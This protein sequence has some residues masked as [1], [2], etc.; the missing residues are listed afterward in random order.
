MTENRDRMAAYKTLEAVF[1]SEAYSNIALNFNTDGDKVT[2]PAF[3]REIVY[4]VIKYRKVL[5]FYI[6]QLVRDGVKSVKGDILIL[7]E[8][9]VYQ[10]LFMD[11][12]PDHSAVDESVKIAKEITRG[13][14]GFVN[15][16]LRN[17]LRKRDEL[18]TPESIR[19]RFKRIST[20]YSCDETIAR[21]LVNQYGEDDTCSILKESLMTPP[22]FIHV[23]TIK[24]DIK[25]LSDDLS[26]YLTDDENF[27]GLPVL[28]VK[29]SRILETDAFKDGKFFIQDISSVNA[30][31]HFDPEA[32]ETLIDVC[33]APGGKSMAMACQMEN[34]GTI[35]CF[36]LHENRLKPVDKTAKKL[37]ITIID[38]CPHDATEVYEKYIEKADKVICD[39]PCSGLGVM[40]RKPEIRYKKF[41]KDLDRLY[42]TQYRILECSSRYVRPGGMLMY[43]TCSINRKENEE[44]TSQFLKEHEDFVVTDSYLTLPGARNI[45]MYDT[46]SP[47]PDCMDRA[48]GFYYCIMERKRI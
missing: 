19:D 30:I 47:Q 12:V 45:S 13:K 16:V 4:G 7:L 27:D 2:N 34:K 29:G 11:S 26:E 43:S 18:K 25:T 31:S 32:D 6:D 44:I 17:F 23:N 37:G 10:I 5:D 40:R 14:S 38:T 41:D 8:M 35:H 39:V 15:G 33:S 42:K 48:D 3:V 46:S 9:G 28:E 36:D 1:K 21:L 24:T 22:L 20:M